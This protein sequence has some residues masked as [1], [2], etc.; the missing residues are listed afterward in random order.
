MLMRTYEDKDFLELVVSTCYI[1]MNVHV[2]RVYILRVTG[3][4]ECPCLQ[5]CAS[6]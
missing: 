2:R 1:P 4:P 6:C 3:R 5:E